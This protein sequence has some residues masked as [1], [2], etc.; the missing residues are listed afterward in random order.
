MGA[1]ARMRMF[2]AQKHKNNSYTP[3]HYFREPT[4]GDI[5]GETTRNLNFFLSFPIMNLP[6]P[7]HA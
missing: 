3:V 6:V 7:L 5:T 1:I 2:L 4:K